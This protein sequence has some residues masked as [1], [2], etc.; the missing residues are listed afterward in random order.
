MTST[1][2]TIDNIN[3][4]IQ[5]TPAALWTEGSAANDPLASQSVSIDIF[6][7]LA[8][9]LEG[10]RT[11]GPLP[12]ARRKGAVP[13]S[14]STALKFSFTERRD[15]TTVRGPDEIC[16]NKL[17]STGPYSVTLDGATTLFDGFSENPIFGTLFVSPV[18][19]LGQHTV[20]VTNQLTDTNLPF[21]DIDFV[22]SHTMS[23]SIV[24]NFPR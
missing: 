19:T 2:F 21:L 3:P 23:L 5:Y 20:S 1:N 24:L 17:T 22:C 12:Y 11:A 4:L 8:D 15:P 18:L 13:P 6:C 16:F 7:C 9:G 10:I 14:L